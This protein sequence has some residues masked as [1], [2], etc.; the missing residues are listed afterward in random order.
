MRILLDS[1]VV[2]AG[3]LSPK[4]PPARLL[5]AWLEG[6]FLLVTSQEQLAELAR[7]F[8]YDKIRRRI[9]PAQARDFVEN[10]DALAL[11]A[12][13]LPR[14]EASPDPAD[15]VILATGLAGEADLIVSGNKDDLLALKE[16]GRIPIV[17]PREALRRLGLAPE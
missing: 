16:F 13:D 4:G 7:V 2:V 14:V 10:V 17:T 1:N 5:S 6:R 15:N 11:V 9:E 3:L 8:D 12:Q